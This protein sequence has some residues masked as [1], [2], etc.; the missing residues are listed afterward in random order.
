ME[1]KFRFENNRSTGV[2]SREFHKVFHG[3][4]LV[5]P[6]FVAT[7]EKPKVC[8]FNTGVIVMDM[9]Q[10]KKEGYTN[11]IEIWMEIQKSE[12]IYEFESMMVGSLR[13]RVLSKVFF[14]NFF[15]CY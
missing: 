8:Y 1:Y 9:V 10:W 3:G 2:L 15:S 11:K 13:L 14:L 6:S 7:I 12:R 4:V 5:G